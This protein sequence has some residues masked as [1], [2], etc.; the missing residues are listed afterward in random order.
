MYES[1]LG[2]TDRPFVAAPRT[3][4]YFPAASI[5]AARETLARAIDR[6]EGPAVLIGPVGTG[7]TLL[8]QLLA[9]EFHS[10]L[11]VSQLPGGGLCSRRALLQA[12][13]FSLGLPYRHLD[14]GEL[15]LSLI[16]HL[17]PSQD[18]PHGMLLIVDEAH[19]LPLRLLE[20]I[21]LLTNLVH[22]GQSRVRLVLAGG[23]ALEE[24]IASPK[25][26]AL[27]QRISAR[28]YLEP[29]NRAETFDYVRSQLA[30]VGGQAGTP[31]GKSDG[32]SLFTDDALDAVFRATDGV[33]RLVNQVCDH[34]LLLA[35][36]GGQTTVDAAGVDEAWADLQQL[37]TPWNSPA[38][39]TAPAA[40]TVV[41]FG[42]LEDDAVEPVPSVP[43][44]RP[45]AGNAAPGATRRT[46]AVHQDSRD[47]AVRDVS[48]GAAVPNDAT[49]GA[50]EFRPVGT[51]G[52]EIE[53]RFDGA[54]DPFGEPFDDEE[55]VIDRFA[56]L[57]AVMW[58]SRPRVSSSAGRELAALLG[59][60]SVELDATSPVYH[61]AYVESPWPSAKEQAIGATPSVGGVAANLPVESAPASWAPAPWAPAPGAA[62]ARSAVPM[63]WNVQM[64]GMDVDVPDPPAVA[65]VA[66]PSAPPGRVSQLRGGASQD[67]QPA[68]HRAAP[69]VDLLQASA[70]SDEV[71]D[72]DGFHHGLPDDDIIVLEDT[73]DEPPLPVRPKPRAHR[74]EYR[75]LFTK[76]RHG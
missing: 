24:R 54:T 38:A 72:S 43:F 71:S 41:E 62:A 59:G 10:T 73:T 37:P 27:C 36:S 32:R 55:V 34:A 76:L 56:S 63:G 64:V 20:E 15:R 51:I 6:A 39:E 74:L 28:C 66:P 53:L 67:A 57:E 33:P 42:G 29:M 58:T 45:A 5:E 30:A 26:E 3:D 1:F 46:P 75:Q 18:C 11:R 7:K 14:E 50:D 8:C 44:R 19:R 48:A 31:A 25:L 23:P 4:R 12:I 22:A 52:P 65:E 21:R 70:P 61:P 35:L 40:D 47:N 13:L 17:A 68:I 2:L 49:T 60:V 16:D 9:E 69:D